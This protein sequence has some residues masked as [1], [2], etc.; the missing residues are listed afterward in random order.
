[1]KQKKSVVLIILII[2]VGIIAV[3]ILIVVLLLRKS[4]NNATTLLPTPRKPA[5]SPVI[6]PPVITKAATV[7]VA[8]VTVAD[9]RSQIMEI[10]DRLARGWNIPNLK[11][12]IEIKKRVGDYALVFVIPTNQTLDPLQIILAKENGTWV[13]KD[14]GSTFPDWEEKVPELFK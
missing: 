13:Y 6:S 10:S 12:D 11:Y 3:G 2:L 9:D 1:M 7:A 5:V 4:V 8:T 14:M